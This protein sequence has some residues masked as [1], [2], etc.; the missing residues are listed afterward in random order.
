MVVD[1]SWKSLPSDTKINTVSL[2]VSRMGDAVKKP[3]KNIIL[4]RKYY[5]FACVLFTIVFRSIYTRVPLFSSLST[6]NRGQGKTSSIKSCLW[7]C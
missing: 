3:L 1:F 7:L 6:L 5:R 4:K 2:E